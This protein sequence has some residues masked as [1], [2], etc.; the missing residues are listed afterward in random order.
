MTLQRGR[1]A[2]SVHRALDGWR[3]EAQQLRKRSYEQRQAMSTARTLIAKAIELLE[4]PDRPYDRD[5]H[6]H[7]LDALTMLDGTDE[8]NKQ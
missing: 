5:V 2:A 7:L 6:L 1:P 8:R 4:D 3:T